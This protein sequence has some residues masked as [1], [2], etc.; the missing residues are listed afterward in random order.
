M[1]IDVA[2]PEIVQRV[3]C[4][5]AHDFIRLGDRGRRHS[6][7]LARPI[8]RLFQASQVEFADHTTG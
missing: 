7:K 6:L 5:Q 4:D 3:V 2:D 8:E 1:G